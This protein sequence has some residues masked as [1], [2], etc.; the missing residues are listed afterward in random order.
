MTMRLSEYCAQTYIASEGRAG[1][2]KAHFIPKILVLCSL[3]SDNLLLFQRD[4]L[5]PELFNVYKS[6]TEPSLIWRWPYYQ[7]IL[8]RA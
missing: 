3:F 7:S 8:S 1:I 2:D 4:G 5:R 6:H